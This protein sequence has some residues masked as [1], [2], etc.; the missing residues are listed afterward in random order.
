VAKGFTSEAECVC[1]F[2]GATVFWENEKSIYL[3]RVSE[4]YYEL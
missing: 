3:G 2:D 4:S 1:R